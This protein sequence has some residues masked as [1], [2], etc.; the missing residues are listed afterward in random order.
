M[1]ANLRKKN[2]VS[3]NSS[4]MPRKQS[5]LT[6]PCLFLHH[7]MCAMHEPVRPLTLGQWQR[8]VSRPGPTARVPAGAAGFAA[9]PLLRRRHAGHG[10]TADT[11]IDRGEF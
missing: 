5:E 10:I 9:S 11:Q 2:V 6:F 7:L 4:E 3:P 1:Q 8:D